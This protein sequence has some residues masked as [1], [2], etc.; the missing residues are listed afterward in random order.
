[1]LIIFERDDNY[2]DKRTLSIPSYLETLL[3]YGS[4][5]A[6]SHMT[7]AYWYLDNVDLLACYPT[8]AETTN[9][10][11]IARWDRIKQSKEVQLLGRLHNDIC[12]VIPYLL[13]GVKLQLKLTKAKRAFY[14]MNTKTDCTT[15]FQ[16][17]E[18]YLIVKR[19]LPNPAYLIAHNP[20]L[21]KGGLARYNLMRVELST[22]TYS[23][24]PKSLSIDIAVF[25]QRQIRLLFTMIKNKDF[26][27]SLDTN[28]YY[29][30]HFDL[31]YFTLFYNCKPIP[32]EG[33]HMN[34]DCEKKLGPGL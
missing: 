27:G 6:A 5:A 7:N 1:M 22:F 30:R 20:T 8:K 29:F 32:N 12:N 31:S 19:I 34:M 15:K 25:G 18:A 10:G 33:L 13:P 26:L 23:A 3:T 11:F 4:D 16:F 24:G 21:T 2:T 28:A 9:K 17:L 14:L